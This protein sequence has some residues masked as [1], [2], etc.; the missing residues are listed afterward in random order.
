MECLTLYD[1]CITESSVQGSLHNSNAF[2]DV[3]HL[4]YEEN[5]EHLIQ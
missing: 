2:H 5:P 1:T 4:N 3:K